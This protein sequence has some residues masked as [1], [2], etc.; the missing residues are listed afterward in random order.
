MAV[1][2]LLGSEQVRAGPGRV[3]LI[4]ELSL[5]AEVRAVPGVLPMVAVLARRGLRRV[6]VANAA[7]EEAR[8]I[9]GLDVVGVDT[10][11][12]AVEVVRSSGRR[13]RIAVA[14][15]RIELVG[16]T[17]CACARGRRGLRPA[18]SRHPRGARPGP[19]AT[20]PGDRA[21]RRPRPAARRPARVGQDAPGADD[22]GI[23]ATAGRRR[24]ARGD[25]RRVGRR[26]RA[27]SASSGGG[28]RSEPL[29]TRSPTPAWSAEGR[30]CRP[31]EVTLG[32]PGGPVPRRASR[33]RPRRP[34]G[35][36]P[37][38]GG[39]ERRDRARRSGRQL[40]RPDSSSWPR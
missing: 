4:G 38:D 17:G 22:P 29:T 8:L 19:C 13:R 36:A 9:A 26:R 5:G 21:G 12:E 1:G 18:G 32:R 6:V 34:R 7:V 35:V 16:R 37:A 23:A 2:I 33:V 15:P 27:R 20:R 25:S 40:S 30:T 24:G 31:G 28:H 10:L 3:A 14:P 39:G 11:A